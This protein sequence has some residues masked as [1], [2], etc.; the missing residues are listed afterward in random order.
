MIELINSSGYW[1]FHCHIE[2]HAEIGMS[3]IFKVG[4]DMEMPPVPNDFPRCGDWKPMMRDE[5]KKISDI[6]TISMITEGEQ[7]KNNKYLAYMIKQFAIYMTYF[8]Q[9]FKLQTS[10][11]SSLSVTLL[12]FIACLLSSVIRV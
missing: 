10:S 1:L 4:E 3:L 8:E 12:L 2:F 6:S 11:A 7:S 9:L 5:N